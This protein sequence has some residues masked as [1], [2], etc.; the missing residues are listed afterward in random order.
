METP[1]HIAAAQAAFIEWNIRSID[2]VFRGRYTARYHRITGQDAARTER[3]DF[4][5][6]SQPTDFFGLNMYT[7]RYVRAAA[8]GGFEELPFPASYPTADASWLR[9]LPQAMYWGP[10]LVHEIYGPKI[11]CITESGAGY[12][13]VPDARGEILDLHRRQYVRQCLA[14]LHRSIGDGAPV[15]GYFLWSFMDN[16][17]WLEGRTKRFGLCYTDYG[18][19][20]RIPKLSAHWY[21]EVMRR[22]EL[23]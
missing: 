19:Q 13:D 11:I 5:L 18:T 23:I 1:A 9:L 6:I 4:A 12:D 3:G 20:K 2:P 14:E 21:R 22:N 16:W 8:R 17:E 10:R 15:R 7:G